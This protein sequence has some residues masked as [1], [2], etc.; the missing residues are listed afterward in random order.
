MSELQVI[1]NQEIGKIDFNY[2]EVKTMLAEKMSLYKDA[3]FTED[4]KKFAK[5]EVATLRKIKTAI[6]D[7]RKEVKNQCLA[8]YKEF[9]SKA[10]E[11]MQLI[12]E[13]ILLINK[14][15]EEFE[16]KRKQEKREQIRQLYEKSVGDMVDYLPIEKIYDARW[17][18]STTTLKAV[19]KEIEAFVAGTRTAVDTIKDM[20][21]DATEEALKM[22]KTSLNLPEA[23]AYINAYEKQK[24]DILKK[25]EEKRREEEERKKQEEIDRIRKEERQRVEEENRIREE[26]KAKLNP[27]Q[28]IPTLWES[29]EDSPFNDEEEPFSVQ[30]PDEGPEATLPFVQPSTLRVLYAVVGTPEELEEMEMM[31]SSIGIYFERKGE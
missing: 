2:Q 25:E 5:S 26:E 18:N 31:L 6:D 16:Q 9:E 23:I 21:S 22:Y 17:E 28:D 4:S 3:V 14:Q 1:V 11:L 24:A 13:P 27:F 8:P 12:D 20:V 15:V 7:K 10:T 29:P 19:G 30:E